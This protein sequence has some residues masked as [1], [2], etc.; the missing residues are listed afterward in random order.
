M[1]ERIEQRYWIKFYK[2]IGDTQVQNTQK[3]QQIF[4]D[5]TMDK[6]Q[7]KVWYT[8]N[9]AA[10]QWRAGYVQAEAEARNF[11]RMFSE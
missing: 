9:M 8:S 4:D 1:S 7:I 11:L 5:D 3:I 2:K 10:P 6:F